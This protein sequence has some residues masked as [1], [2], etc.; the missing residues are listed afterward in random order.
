MKSKLLYVTVALGMMLGFNSCNLDYF[1]SDELN[2]NVLLNSAS[3]AEYVIDGCYAMLKEEY[4]YVEYSSGNSYIRHYMMDAEY[5]SDNICLSGQTTDPLAKAT[6][7]KM[8][9]NLKN[10]ETLCG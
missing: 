10:I 5:P 4:E 6:W 1:P 2:S 3:G 8:T 9:D 7:Y